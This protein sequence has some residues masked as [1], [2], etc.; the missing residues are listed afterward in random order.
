MTYQMVLRSTDWVSPR[1]TLGERVG[2]LVQRVEIY[3]LSFQPSYYTSL[4]IL[5]T[6]VK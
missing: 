2:T 3:L 6:L 5:D 1:K 4:L